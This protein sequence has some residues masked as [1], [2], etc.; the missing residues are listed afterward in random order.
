MIRSGEWFNLCVEVLLPHLPDAAYRKVSLQEAFHGISRLT[1]LDCEGNAHDALVRILGELVRYGKLADGK[2]AV[3]AFLEVIKKGVGADIQCQLTQL[4]GAY[5]R[6]M[7]RSPAPAPP[8]EPPH[9]RRPGVLSQARPIASSTDSRAPVAFSIR[10]RQLLS[11]HDLAD[12]TRHQGLK[13]AGLF[14]LLV[15]LGFIGGWIIL[16]VLQTIDSP[17][18]DVLWLRGEKRAIIDAAFFAVCVVTYLTLAIWVVYRFYFRLKRRVS[19]F[20]ERLNAEFPEHVR[21]FGGAGTFTDFIAVAEV[22]CQLDSKERVKREKVVHRQAVGEPLPSFFS[23]QALGSC[24][25]LALV[26]LGIV[27]LFAFCGVAFVRF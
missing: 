8:A 6:L 25:L 26:I 20:V 13:A 21:N 7:A 1:G 15:L 3:N 9:D 4:Q 17:L 2:W 23:T 11:L 24:V 19:K 10:V 18:E 22:L 27:L 5:E 16:R 12:G 14:L